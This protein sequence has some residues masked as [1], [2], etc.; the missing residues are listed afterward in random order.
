MFQRLLAEEERAEI[1][2]KFEQ[3]LKDL[4]KGSTSAVVTFVKDSL[5]LCIE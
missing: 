3:Q 1:R 5:L 4:G 2:T